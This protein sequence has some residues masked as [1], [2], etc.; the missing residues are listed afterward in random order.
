M[1]IFLASLVF[2][3]PLLGGIAVDCRPVVA[4]ASVGLLT[5]GTLRA[6]PIWAK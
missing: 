3:I 1:K 5:F 2:L 4:L 6:C